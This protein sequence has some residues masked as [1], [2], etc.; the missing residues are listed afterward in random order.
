MPQQKP[1]PN[2]ANR[3]RPEPGNVSNPLAHHDHVSNRPDDEKEDQ[4]DSGPDRDNP[5][6]RSHPP[7][8]P[9]RH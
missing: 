5:L 4:A 6:T 3:E 2:Q 1:E 7:S 8:T 9:T